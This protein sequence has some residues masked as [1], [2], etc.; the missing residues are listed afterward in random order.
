METE[1][2]EDTETLLCFLFYLPIY[3][4]KEKK[5]KNSLLGSRKGSQNIQ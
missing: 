4:E 5:T 2:R 3:P 1:M